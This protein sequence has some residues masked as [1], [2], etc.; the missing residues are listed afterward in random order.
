MAAAGSDAPPP[1]T[2]EPFDSSGTSGSSK[3]F[4]SFESSGSPGAGSPGAFESSG[5]P[6]ASGGSAD[7]SLPAAVQA[8]QNNSSFAVKLIHSSSAIGTPKAPYMLFDAT[9]LI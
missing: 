2:A 9:P 4:E 1:L 8:A 7:S 6:G 5:S 3:S